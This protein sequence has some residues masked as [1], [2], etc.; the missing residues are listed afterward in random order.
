M[1]LLVVIIFLALVMS[2]FS[3]A[4]ATFLICLILFFLIQ[5]ITNLEQDI[6]KLIQQQKVVPK[7]SSPFI[8]EKDHQLQIRTTQDAVLSEQPVH[9]APKNDSSILPITEEENLIHKHPIS[10]TDPWLTSPKVSSAHPQP[11]FQEDVI[12]TKMKTYLLSGNPIAKIGMLVLF[13]GVAFLLKYVTA[14]VYISIEIRLSFVALG[15]I[16]MICLGHYFMKNKPQFGTILQGGGCGILY[17]TIY[18]AFEYYQ[19]LP[20]HLAFALLLGVIVFTAFISFLQDSKILASL[21]ILGGLLAPLLIHDNS[22]NYILLFS[23]YSILNLAIFAFAWLKTWRELNLI[24]FIFTFIFSGLWGWQSYQKEYLFVTEIFLSGFFLLYVCIPILFALRHPTYRAN[25]IDRLLVFGAPFVTFV[26]QISLMQN[27]H[28]GLAWTAFIL[29]AFYSILAGVCFLIKK[30]SLQ[31]LVIIYSALAVFF[32]TVSVP[33]FFSGLNTAAIWALE[34]IILLWYEQRQP[35]LLTRVG[36]AV[37]L[38]GSDL[39][40]VGQSGDYII[41]QE[42]INSFYLSGIIIALA[43]IVC[44]YFYYCKVQLNEFL[45]IQF[46]VVFMVL[47]WLCWYAV[48]LHEI[49]FYVLYDYQM[50]AVLLL[51]AGTSLVSWSVGEWLE[52]Q[53]LRLSAFALLPIMIFLSI[54]AYGTYIHV[55]YTTLIA[56][57]GCILTLY[58]LLYRCEKFKIAE[59]DFL[60]CF[61]YLF[62]TWLVASQLS[63]YLFTEKYSDTA[64]IICWGAIPAIMLLKATYS[65]LWPF[66]TFEMAYKQW[67]GAILAFCISLWFL[68]SNFSSG[69]MQTLTYIPLLN[70]LDI[71]VALVLTS[72]LGWLLT[73]EKFLRN[74]IE[75]YSMK[76]TI[77]FLVAL[78]F[79]WFNAIILRSVHHWLGISYTAIDLWDST[80]VQGSLS[81]YWTMFALVTT[82]VATR[83]NQRMLWFI[84]AGLIVIIIAK[85][86]LI[87]LSSTNTLQRIITFIGV[88]I[89]LLI[90]GYISPLPPKQK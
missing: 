27:V 14:H 45:N 28:H 21:S 54:M 68:T 53:W 29:G 85:L 88:G 41:S 77:A 32:G 51:A 47:G 56:W 73:S 40:F 90:N 15:A 81:L 50:G 5:R 78:L 44:A 35:R 26:L 84:G 37:I 57:L 30:E 31:K 65:C 79:V 87:D 66:S 63:L 86:F 4:A 38:L 62:V 39:A 6:R 80:A 72:L 1:T 3:T 13:F 71:T 2:F 74:H 8:P 60:H 82:F 59:L 17:M 64:I 20:L 48:N 19:L 9:V 33:L 18:A 43:N 16:F 70:P 12:L 24:G 69:D 58:F 22:N 61:I 52:W 75:N 11:S 49:N 34:S 23:Y 25:Y 36:A 83:K 10:T 55:V 46:S 89:L 42:I 67:A 76:F 7:N